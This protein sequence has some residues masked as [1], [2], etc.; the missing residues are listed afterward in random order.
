MI[1]LQLIFLL[2]IKWFNH[3]PQQNT[4]GITTNNKFSLKQQMIFFDNKVAQLVGIVAKISYYLP[5]D[6][7]ITLYLCSCTFTT[8]LR[9]V[10]K[11]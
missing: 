11:D 4:L 3:L 6:T 1:T 8:T 2:I 10:N 5:F 9:I 7:Q